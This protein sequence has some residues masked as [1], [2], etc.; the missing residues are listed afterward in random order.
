MLLTRFLRNSLRNR[1]LRGDP[2][3]IIF[4]TETDEK[5]YKTQMT[6]MSKVPQVS[7]VKDLVT[8]SGGIELA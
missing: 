4:L 8:M 3:I 5:C 2:Y 7:Y 1:L 6:Q